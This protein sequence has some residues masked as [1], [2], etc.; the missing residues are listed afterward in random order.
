MFEQYIS[1]VVTLHELVLFALYIKKKPY[2]I[3]LI[4]QKYS[5]EIRI[6]IRVQFS[7]IFKI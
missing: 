3:A 7:H 4:S 5:T 6:T 2:R 1:K